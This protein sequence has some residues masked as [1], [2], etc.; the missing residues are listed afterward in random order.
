ML[1]CTSGLVIALTW[2]LLPGLDGRAYVDLAPTLGRIVRESQTILLAEVDRFGAEKGAVILKKVRDLKGQSEAGPLKHSLVRAGESGV[3]WPILDWAAPGRRCV[4]FQSGKAAVVCLGEVWYQTAAGEDGWW[5]IGVARPDLPLAYYGS[6]SRLA[7]AIPLMTA[8]KTAVITTLPHGANQEGASVDLALNRAR[9]PGLVK[10]QRIRASLSMPNVAMGVGAKPAHVVGMGRTGREDV[11]SLRA[12]L[13]STDAIVRAESATDLGFAGPGAVEAV[14]DL[15]KLLEDEPAVRLAA[16]S[17]LLRI[18]P[19]EARPVAVLSAGLA[20]DDARTRRL[21]ARVTGLGGPAAAPLAAGL[22]TLLNDSDMMV[23]RTALQAIATLGP[24]AAS[25]REAVTGLLTKRETAVDAADALGR[26]GPAARPSLKALTPLLTSATRDERWAAV[27]AMAQIGGPDAAP[28]VKV[29]Q[30]ELPRASEI[31]GYNMLV[32]LALLGPVARDALPA[33]RMARVR[34]PVLRQA[35]AWAI[36]PGEDM[37]RLGGLGDVDFAQ[38]IF[39]AYVQEVGDH[40]RPVAQELARKILAGQAGEVPAWG[41][42]LLARFPDDTLPV[43]TTGLTDKERAPRQR[44]VLALGSMG[45]TAAR[46]KPQVGEALKAATD[47]REQRL[48]QWCLR[49]MEAERGN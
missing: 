8:G 35:T 37:P 29:L 43:L 42:K 45:P 30:E 5:R 17:A 46:V 38:Y 14:E 4:V 31:E 21:A 20:G 23:R 36:D 24:A 2:W 10:V 28:A 7:E 47:E 27:R 18:K 22:G 34:N 1:R 44:A 3:D 9:L 15:A 41:Y 6:V 48:L 26:M 16:A 40:F 32:Y 11:A 33:V 49:E 12:K 13:R 39:T 25:T 19:G